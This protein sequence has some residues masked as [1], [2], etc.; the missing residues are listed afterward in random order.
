MPAPRAAGQVPSTYLALHVRSGPCLSPSLLLRRITVGPAL[1]AGGFL[2]FVEG[3][4]D[5]VEQTHGLKFGGLGFKTQLYHLLA[6]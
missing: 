3:S 1:R 2:S 4:W 6:V 5:S